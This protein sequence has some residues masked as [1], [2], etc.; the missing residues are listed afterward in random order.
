MGVRRKRPH[1]FAQ[2]QPQADH[3]HVLAQAPS[4]KWFGFSHR[5]WLTVTAISGLA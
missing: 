4:T 1:H 3:A 5:P 2:S